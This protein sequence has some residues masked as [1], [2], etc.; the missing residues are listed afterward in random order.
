MPA[1]AQEIRAAIESL[2]AEELLRIRQFAVWRLRALGNNGGRDH[3]DLLQE[4]VVRTVAGDRHW[5]ER[6]VSF[7]HHLIGAMRSISSHWA[8][9]LAGRS[10]AEIDAAGGNLIE[11]MPS[12]T[13]SPEMELAAKQEVEAVERLLAGDAAALRVLGCIRRGMTGPETQQAIGYSK[14]E[15]ETVMKHMRRKLRGAGARG[16]N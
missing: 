7:P 13:V 9:E 8:A 15:Y 6:G 4:A 2:T 1:S 3:E 16:A 10:P 14:T 5:N 12:P 11:T